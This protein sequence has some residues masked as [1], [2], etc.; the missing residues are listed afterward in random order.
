MS[1]NLEL[2]SNPNTSP[3]TLALLAKDKDYTI[4]CPIATNPNTSPETLALLGKRPKFPC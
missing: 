2:A 3:K 4:R 1:A